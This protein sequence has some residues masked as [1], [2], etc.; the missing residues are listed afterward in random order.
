MTMTKRPPTF[1]ILAAALAL[2]GCFSLSPKPPESLL[3]LTP[4]AMPQAAAGRIAPSADA[5][6]VVEP[7]TPQEL[8]TN[9]VPV[10]ES[11]TAVAY[12]K[13]AQ[14]VDLPAALFRSLLSDTIAASTGR[15]VLD[16]RQFTFDP[17]TRLTGSLRVFGVDA[18]R[19]EAVVTYDAALARS[20]VLVETRRF[21]ARIPVAAI[22][23]ASVA[24]AL[25]EAANRVAAE[26][27]AWVGAPPAPSS[28][29]TS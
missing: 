25:N 6:T 23:A 1:A 7:T 13:D 16:D 27:A 19:N 2:G 5:I 14:W 8:Q 28:P 12:L 20:D 3:R 21:E 11:M 9:R 10:Q 4:A 15:V 22:D 29:G 24:P 26:V 18:M 17:G